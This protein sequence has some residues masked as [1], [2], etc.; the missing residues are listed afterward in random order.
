METI[1][2][3]PIYSGATLYRATLSQGALG[4]LITVQQPHDKGTRFSNC[5]SWYLETL[6]KDISD[7]IFI[8]FGQNWKIDHGM[9]AVI[10]EA[11]KVLA[12]AYTL[13]VE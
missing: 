6:L 11:C 4:A 3:S 5:S 2:Q 8:D 12:K 10:D 13:E 1:L 7:S 9:V